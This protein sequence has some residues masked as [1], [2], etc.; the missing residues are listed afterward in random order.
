MLFVSNNFRMKGLVFL[1]RT[2]ADLKKEGVPPF[3][4]LVLGKDRKAPYL[5]LGKK[6]DISEETIFVGSTN[7]PEKYYGAADLFIH[8]AFY[9]AFSL[10][11]LEAL[12]SGLPVITTASTG[13][14][15]VLN[16]GEDGFVIN[17]LEDPGELKAGI[18]Y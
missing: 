8:P 3:K 18:R 6:M 16:P 11:V 1:M 9:D 13:A 12:A 4:L 14:S 5:R 17:S 7:E 10:T 2:L 15:E